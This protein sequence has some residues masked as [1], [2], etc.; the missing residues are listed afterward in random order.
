MMVPVPAFEGPVRGGGT[1][2]R[3]RKKVVEGGQ[4]AIQD[5]RGGEFVEVIVCVDRCRKVSKVRADS[6]PW[7]LVSM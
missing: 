6:C 2:R 3:I 5:A 1:G 7:D 4:C